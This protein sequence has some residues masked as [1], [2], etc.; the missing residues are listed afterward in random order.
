IILAQVLAER[1]W[2]LVRERSGGYQFHA[3]PHALV[4]P[5]CR[6]CGV[7]LD[8]PAWGRNLAPTGRPP[9][10]C[11]AACRRDVEFERRRMY[12]RLRALSPPSAGFSTVIDPLG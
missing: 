3:N 4:C 1:P 10:Y 2:V 9:R 8:D 7:P 11:S 6:H 5:C 12:S